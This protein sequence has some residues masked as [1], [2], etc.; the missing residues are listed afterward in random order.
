M[1]LCTVC[2]SVPFASLPEPLAGAGFYRIG[3]NSDL[4]VLIFGPSDGDAVCND[5]EGFPWHA[6]LG[7]LASSAHSCTLCALVWAG[8]NQWMEKRETALQ[9]KFYVVFR[10]T[11]D[12]P[13]P[14]EDRLL[15]TK[16]SGGAPG[17][18]VYV[19]SAPRPGE[20]VAPLLTGVAF[21]VAASKFLDD[22]QRASNID[23][24]T[25]KST[26]I[27]T[28]HT[29]ASKGLRFGLKRLPF[30]SFIT[31]EELPGWS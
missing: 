23:S 15:L 6:N 27:G 3:N 19:K 7:A 8:V 31:P 14:T 12:H 17:F 4:P 28:N 26:R 11:Y 24:L 22:K 30:Y 9:Q 5:S 13:V 25:M 10:E 20:T 16:R 29:C 18:L 21:S 1:G 2:L